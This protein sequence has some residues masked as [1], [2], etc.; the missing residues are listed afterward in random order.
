[1]GILKNVWLTWNFNSR[2]FWCQINE[3]VEAKHQKNEKLQTDTHRKLDNSFN[4]EIV[5]Y[6]EEAIAEINEDK[7]EKEDKMKGG[8]QHRRMNSNPE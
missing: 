6:V 8:R 7:E 5:H 1:M 2:G 4:F 3:Q